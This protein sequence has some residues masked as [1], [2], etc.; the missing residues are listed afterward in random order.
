MS[1][2]HDLH[3]IK[4]I[5][6]KNSDSTDDVEREM[7][8]REK[9]RYIDTRTPTGYFEQPI[10]QT[11]RSF[12]TVQTQFVS[13]PFY[14]EVENQPTGYLRDAYGRSLNPD[15][16]HR[17]F[18]DS[19]LAR[20][21][22]GNE[23]GLRPTLVQE[24]RLPILT[25]AA[26]YKR[27]F[28]LNSRIR[29]LHEGTS[30]R[31]HR[32]AP[33]K[34]G[35]FKKKHGIFNPGDTALFEKTGL[36]T[37]GTHVDIPTKSLKDMVY[38]KEE[39]ITPI[40]IDTS[41]ISKKEKQSNSESSSPAST[42]TEKR[43]VHIDLHESPTSVYGTPIESEGTSS[44]TSPNTPFTSMLR[45]YYKGPSTGRATVLNPKTGRS[46]AVDGKVYKELRSQFH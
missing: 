29:A 10:F 37:L 4:K 15:T 19:K 7:F 26:G 22:S 24:T 25:G 46:I 23:R 1:D 6:T 42:P 14:I 8:W 39:S 16:F 5:L 27:Q 13:N 40:N 30:V 32:G 43:P 35:S 21:R 17:V 18:S 45:G 44:R 2:V 36:G 33:K 9:R 11:Y 34:L 3:D 20:M 31:E 41:Y 28:D 38:I 12:G